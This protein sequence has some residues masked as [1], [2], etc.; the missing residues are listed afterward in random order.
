MDEEEKNE[1]ISG[2]IFNMM[3]WRQKTM[4]IY[5]TEYTKQHN[6]I[7][8]KCRQAKEELLNEKLCRNR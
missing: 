8:N 1:G 4:P 2:G 3:Q 7:N 5:G 6:E